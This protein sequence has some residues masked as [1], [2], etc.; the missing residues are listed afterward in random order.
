MAI[1]NE[2]GYRPN[3][4]ALSLHGQ[5]APLVGLVARRVEDADLGDLVGRLRPPLAA[6]GIPLVLCPIG[7]SL[8]DSPFLDLLR[9]GR[10]GALVVTGEDAADPALMEIARTGR[11]VVAVEAP[12]AAPGM[13]RT[14]VRGA[15]QA[16][17]GALSMGASGAGYLLAPKT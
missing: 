17:L 12:D 7:E 15:A 14:D 11:A 3:G 13:V 9:D 16:I 2:L 10:L 1:V 4:N 5:R 8:R 6:A